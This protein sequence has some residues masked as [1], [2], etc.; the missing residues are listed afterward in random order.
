MPIKAQTYS[1]S[2]TTVQE[3]GKSNTTEGNQTVGAVFTFDE[4]NISSTV[5]ISFISSTKA[6]SFADDELPINT[7]LQTITNATQESWNS[8]VLSKITTTET[9]QDSLTLLYSAL[10]GMHLL[11]SNRTGEN[12][13]WESSEPYYDDLFTLWDLFRCNTALMHILQ[14]VAYEEQ[15]RSMIDVWRHDGYLPD[16]R[17][18]NYNGRIQ[19]GTNADN[20]LADAYVK[21]VRGAINWN[22]GYEAMLKDAEVQPE[23]NNDP[24]APDSS[25]KEGRGALPDWKQYGYITPK[26]TRAVSRAIEYSGNDFGLYQVA[27]GL[28]IPKDAAKYLSRSRNWR[29]HWNSDA[30]SLGFEGFVMQRRADGT[31]IEY[32]DPLSCGGC[33]WH[34]PYY[35]GLPWEYSFGAHHDMATLIRFSNGPDTF[36]KRLDTIFQSNLNP[37]G[38]PEFNNTIFGVGNEPSFTSPYLFNF[39]GQQ[40]KSVERSRQIAKDY[41]NP[42]VSG[43]PGNSDAGAMQSWLVWNIIGLYPITGQTTFLIGSPWFANLNI[44]L[45][46]SKQLVINAVGGGDTSYYVQ[47]L[48]VN[49]QP[50]NRGWLTWNDIFQNGGTLN[51]ELGPEPVIW[52][53]GESPP[54]PASGDSAK[55]PRPRYRRRSRHE[56]YIIPTVLLGF[57]MF[58]AVLGLVLV[59]ILR[60]KEKAIIGLLAVLILGSRKKTKTL[61]DKVKCIR[62]EKISADES[63]ESKAT[64]KIDDEE[65]RSSPKLDA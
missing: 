48:K 23:N 64:D 18:S 11:P 50:W 49:N 54:S 2:G 31:F 17:S 45:G 33:Y 28:R 60:R 19:G 14:P 8:Q 10:Y 39:V 57:F 42:G 5:G 55:A 43:L 9:N 46:G 3:F 47:S 58:S 12:P 56:K 24:Q 25:T 29:N 20:I 44:S 27:T 51:F 16:A 65:S 15:I 37:H 21:G 59:L 32:E 61:E 4:Q 30:K 1:G 26:Y 34:D 35:Q 52:D 53:T 6:C 36:A 22:E 62:V 7:S 38:D 63:Y 41:F 40:Y 13:H